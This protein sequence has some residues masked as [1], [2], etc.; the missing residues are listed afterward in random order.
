MRN[1]RIKK[2]KE[3][4]AD[5]VRNGWE[6]KKLGEVC[7]IERGSSPRPIEKYLT[8]NID[9]VNWIKIGNTKGVDKYI[10]TTKEGD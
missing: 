4:G 6:V 2:K 8:Q 10:Y 9:G 3:L 1:F 7:I 5:D